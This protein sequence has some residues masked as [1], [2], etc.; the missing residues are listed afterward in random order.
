MVYACL[1]GPDCNRVENLFDE[2]VVAKNPEET[3]KDVVITTAHRDE[4]LRNAVWF[5]MNC[6]WPAPKYESKC[7]DW[8]AVSVANP[9]WESEIRQQLL[10]N[11]L[12]ESD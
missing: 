10:T 6:A 7:A 2:A 1:W 8:I 4:S 12:V 11:D 5:F 3:H 9:D